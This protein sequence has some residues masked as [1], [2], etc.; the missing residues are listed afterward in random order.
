MGIKLI[1]QRTGCQW[2]GSVSQNEIAGGQVEMCGKHRKR[3]DV[4]PGQV[5]KVDSKALHSQFIRCLSRCYILLLIRL[6]FVSFDQIQ[7]FIQRE[8]DISKLSLSAEIAWHPE[9]ET[10]DQMIRAA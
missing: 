2:K 10:S 3:N 7:I 1:F 4:W 9:V 6:Y 8:D 5:F